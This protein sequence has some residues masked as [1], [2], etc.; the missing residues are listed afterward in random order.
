MK[1][2][3]KRCVF[4]MLLVDIFLL[5]LICYEILIFMAYENDLMGQESILR[6]NLC[7]LM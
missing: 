2:I 1:Q 3:T 4:T 6:Q 7:S 5:N